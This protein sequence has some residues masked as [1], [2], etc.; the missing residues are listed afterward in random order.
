MIIKIYRER[1]TNKKSRGGE[2]K[3]LQ[4]LYFVTTRIILYLERERDSK[5]RARSG[6][7]TVLP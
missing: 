4:E 2:D 6:T 1:H 3:P 5:N 7:T